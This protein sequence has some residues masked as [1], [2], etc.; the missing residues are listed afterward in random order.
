MASEEDNLQ[1]D[2]VAIELPA[3]PGWSKKFTPKKSGTPQRN[4]IVFISPTGEEIKSKR[5][6]DQYLKSHPGGPAASEFD[7]GTGDTPRRSA[8]L[9]EKSKAVVEPT[10][11]S[12]KKKQRRSSTKGAQEKSN[13]DAEEDATGEKDATAEETKETV[14]SA[15]VDAKDAEDEDVI[16]GKPNT[17]VVETK[18]D[19]PVASEEPPAVAPVGTNTENQNATVTVVPDAK[20]EESKETSSVVPSAKADESKK[21]ETREVM[22][23]G[24]ETPD[25]KVDSAVTALE[26][27]ICNSKEKEAEEKAGE[28]T[29]LLQ[30]PTTG[31]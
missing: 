10:T 28:K 20:M 31:S 18:T 14:E 16:P 8:R 7:W 2:V 1:N 9:S 5:Q 27:G 21:E 12:P 26:E 4:E 30:E 19:T 29:A 25:G 3:P 24:K 6:L 15:T 22:N 17:E 13:A 23:V 11:Q